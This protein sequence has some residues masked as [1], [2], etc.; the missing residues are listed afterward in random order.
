MRSKLLVLCAG[1]VIGSAASLAFKQGRSPGQ[2]KRD[3]VKVGPEIYKVV[4]DNERIR[5]ME[6]TFA[7]RASIAMHD[8]P[9]H[10]AYAMSDGKLEI[11]PEGKAKAVHDVKAGMA[12]W[13]PAEAHQA[14]NAGD[15]ELRLLV[16][17]LK[18]PAPR[19][20]GAGGANAG[21]R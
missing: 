13:I 21:K 5:A 1:V 19:P 16:V 2:E 20:Q 11:T 8:H 4:L 14:R 6:V 9:D 12:L 3:P 15:T 7:R 17:E 10:M 18:E